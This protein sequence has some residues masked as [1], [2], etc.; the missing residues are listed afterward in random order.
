VVVAKVADV[1][2]LHTRDPGVRSGVCTEDSDAEPAAG[3][4]APVRPLHLVRPGHRSPVDRPGP[5]S[6]AE[7]QAAGLVRQASQPITGIEQLLPVMPGLRVLLPGGGLRRGSTVAVAG[8]AGLSPGHES[9]RAGATRAGPGNP[10]PARPRGATSLLFGLL[11]E[12]SSAGSW[13][14][15]VGLPRLGLAAA[16]EAGV[17]V[18][19]L[20]LVPNPG[21]EWVSVVA[22]L[23]DG[24]DIV[25]VAP[26]G[27]VNATVTSRLAARARQRGS[28]L[29]ACGGWPGV[30][31]VVEVV[32][33]TWHGLGQG[34]GR[35]RAQELE[36]IAYGRGAAARTRR[37]WLWL[38][39]P[40]GA[41]DPDRSR[42]D[43]LDRFELAG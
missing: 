43:E 3:P 32:E 2:A 31:L 35:L 4:L 38:P 15:V 36:I 16:A 21:P 7:L 20:A 19:R 37:L 13:C 23:L 41:P 14:G 28:V 18:D 1:V 33:A 25:V 17:A 5:R 12:A 39:G 40:S 6:V 10:A 34:R 27:P 42:M 9:A 29:V 11:A 8:M 26:A 30:D 22:T 24:L